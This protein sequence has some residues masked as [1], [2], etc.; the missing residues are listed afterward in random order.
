M[1]MKKLYIILFPFL[2]LCLSGCGKTSPSAVETAVVR[3]EISYSDTT[4]WSYVSSIV[5]RVTGSE[6]NPIVDTQSVDSTVFFPDIPT[7]EG[8]IFTAFGLDTTGRG[9]LWGKS[10]ADITE[11]TTYV[12]IMLH[13]LLA[14]GGDT[15]IILRDALP[16][17]LPCTDS[18][19]DSLGMLVY[20]SLGVVQNILPSDSF[21]DFILDPM[22]H[23]IIVPSDQPQE[24]YDSYRIHALKF[25]SFVFDGGTIFFSACD[26]G[27]NGGD[28]LNAG[29]LF[30]SG[31]SLDTIYHTA[32]INIVTGSHPI[33]DGIDTLRGDPFASYNW[34]R[35]YP[36][37]AWRLSVTNYC[38]SESD[39]TIKPTLLLYQYGSGLVLLS[40]QPLEYEYDNGIGGDDIGILLPRIL[41]VLCSGDKRKTIKVCKTS[42]IN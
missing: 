13:P 25:N 5:L 26:K 6:F 42:S 40:S 18:I 23:I 4:L 29:I 17:G 41:E 28:I 9:R 36:P 38:L 16:W 24:F 15:I 30:P 7:G 8:R 32:P 33:V 12:S 39:T 35:D 1:G 19:L 14:D 27:W 11:D 22:R 10:E 20:D 21:A 34:F 3:V 37:D 31:V 2:V